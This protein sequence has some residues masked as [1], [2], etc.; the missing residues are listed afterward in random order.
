MIININLGIFNTSLDNESLFNKF[1]REYNH[2]S[3]SLHKF[4][5]KRQICEAITKDFSRVKYKTV[6]LKIPMSNQFFSKY[7]QFSAELNRIIKPLE[8]K[9][10]QNS[11]IVKQI[12]KLRLRDFIFEILIIYLYLNLFLITVLKYTNIERSYFGQ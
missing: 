2:D 4:I 12:Y 8:L 5:Q 10:E 6:F 1:I 3:S 9:L 11:K 7:F